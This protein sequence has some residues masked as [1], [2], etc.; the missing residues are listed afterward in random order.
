M[1]WI[2]VAVAMSAHSVL[3]LFQPGTIEQVVSGEMQ[4]G[5]GMFILVALFWLIPLVMAFLTQV[6][7]DSANRWVNL[8]LGIIFTVFN[9]WHLTEHLSPA[10]V[11]QI[12]IV[13]STVAATVLIAWYAWKWPPQES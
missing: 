6:L 12:L 2:F 8:V 9:I 13:G 1:L 7:R 10:V 3:G 5:A 11:H 4:M